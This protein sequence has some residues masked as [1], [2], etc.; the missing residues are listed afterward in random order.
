MQKIDTLAYFVRG[1]VG[2]LCGENVNFS[3]NCNPHTVISNGKQWELPCA[4]GWRRDCLLLQN[5]TLND[6]TS[7]KEE[8]Q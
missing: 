2:N 6:L 4:I 3:T 1:K 8:K 7:L 5:R